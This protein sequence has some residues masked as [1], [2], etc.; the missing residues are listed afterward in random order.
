MNVWLISSSCCPG[1]PEPQR[2]SWHPWQPQKKNIQD[3]ATSPA[4]CRIPVWW[5]GVWSFSQAVCWLLF[6]MVLF[7]SQ[8]LKWWV[9]L[10]LQHLIMYNK[11]WSNLEKIETNSSIRSK[12][13]Q[14]IRHQN[15]KNFCSYN[16]NIYRLLGATESNVT[17]C[18]YYFRRS[19]PSETM[20]DSTT[21]S[22]G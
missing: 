14:R 10:L 22:C 5:L 11:L 1:L 19:L 20:D 16:W 15:C 9:R 18:I 3:F 8:Y 2:V 12:R 13:R 7:F 21:C 4:W 17:R 6:F